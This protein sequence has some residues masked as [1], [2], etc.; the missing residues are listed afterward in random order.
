MDSVIDQRFSLIELLDPGSLKEVAESFSSCFG[1][2]VFIVGEKGEE[3]IAVPA[4]NP[5]CK[6]AGA[7]PL[8][9]KCEEVRR[10]LY[11]HPI[12]GSR[13]FQTKAHCGLRYAIF[14]LVH[15]FATVGRVIIGPFIDEVQDQGGK[16][17]ME[18]LAK[19]AQ[20]YNL[21]LTEIK[22]IPVFHPE[23]LKLTL[24]L[25]LKFLDAFLFINAKRLI[26]SRLHLEAIYSSREA[27]FR[28]V[29]LQ[30]SGSKED[31]EEIEKLKNMF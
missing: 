6:A 15:E 24:R 5:L 29:E 28:Q 1:L 3:V 20:T 12:E 17:A 14:P 22:K 21:P 18:T 26:T 9:A 27:I 31:K 19:D 8:R 11:Q 30:D 4:D 16:T 7:S 23:K 13:V 10:R 2:G 25:L